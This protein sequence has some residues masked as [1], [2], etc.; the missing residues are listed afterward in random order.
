M[1][2]I[3]SSIGLG[4]VDDLSYKIELPETSSPF[5]F[6]R[7]CK[8][9]SGDLWIVGGRGQVIHRKNGQVQTYK[10]SESDLYGVY[11]IDDE[12][13]WVVGANG[14]LY[15]TNNAGRNWVKQYSDIKVGF[16][17]IDCTPFGECCIVGE[18]GIMLRTSNMGTTWERIKSGTLKNLS[19]IDFVDSKL[20]W[21]VGESGIVL[22]TSDGGAN[23]FQQPLIIKTDQ[24]NKKSVS[25]L[26]SVKFFN[27]KHGYVAGSEGIFQTTDGGISWK[28]ELSDERIIGICFDK[29]S[30][31]WAIS[32]NGK[33]WWSTRLELIGLVGPQSTTAL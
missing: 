21:A 6:Y 8:V 11:F 25:A 5:S 33:N 30:K 7:Y 22:K 10:V 13:G 24:L 27:D 9:E 26:L 29:A 20:G 23:W 28:Q 16:E 17:A 1:L 14:A 18:K 2:T 12:V 32:T 3:Q 4:M 19:A 15:F 31:V